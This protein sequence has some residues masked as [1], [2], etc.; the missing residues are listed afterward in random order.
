MKYVIHYHINP[1]IK[2][3]IS[4]VT[5]VSRI[6]VEVPLL[7]HIVVNVSHVCCANKESEV[8]SLQNDPKFNPKTCAL[9]QRPLSNAV[10]NNICNVIFGKRFDYDDR[11][12]TE[13][14]YHLTRGYAHI[15]IF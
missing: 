11:H 13:S 4:C 3:N 9:F 12:F 14:I 8:A 15:A 6:S 1:F 5:L 10:S 2:R 7:K